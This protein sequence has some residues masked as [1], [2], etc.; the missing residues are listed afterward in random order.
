MWRFPFHY[1]GYTLEWSLVFGAH[2]CWGGN[3]TFHGLYKFPAGFPYCFISMYF[4]ATLEVACSDCHGD[5]VIYVRGARDA[6]P[7]KSVSIQ[8]VCAGISMSSDAKA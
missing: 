8:S 5:L 7:R 2:L 3:V 1:L 4:G 6:P